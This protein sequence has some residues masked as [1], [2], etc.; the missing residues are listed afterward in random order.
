[1]SPRSNRIFR[2]LGLL[3]LSATAGCSLFNAPDLGRLEADQ[4]A[5]VEGKFV[6]LRLGVSKITVRP[7]HEADAAKPLVGYPGQVEIAAG[8]QRLFANLCGPSSALLSCRGAALLEFEAEAGHA[9]R[10]DADLNEQMWIVDAET[11]A[12]VARSRP[13]AEAQEAPDS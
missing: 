4:R 10:V 6:P 9:Y 13:F 3:A 8:P 11:G 1:M 5:A 2:A 12:I 7:V